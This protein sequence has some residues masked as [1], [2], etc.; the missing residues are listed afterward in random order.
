MTDSPEISVVV[1][2]LDEEDALEL[3]HERLTLA[4]EG[5]GKSYEVIYIDDGS[6]DSSPDILKKLYEAD[7]HVVVIKFR[8][9]FGK[10]AA[11]SCGFSEARGEI[12]F[13][14][15][16]DLQDDPDEIPNFLVKLDEGYDLVSGYKAKRYD[17]WIK[18]ASSRFFNWVVRLTSGVK[19]HDFNCGFKAY[20]SEVVREVDIYG[21][22]H[23]YVPFLAAAR[24]FRVG[25]I[26][27]KHHPRK[28]GRSKYGWDRYM[29]G[30][31]DLLTATVITRF[32][33]KPLHLFGGFGIAC[34]MGGFVI[35]AY[36]TVVWFITHAIGHRPL[37]DLG[38]LLMILGIQLISIGLI[39]EM[40]IF[41]R[42]RGEREY[43]TA[44]VLNH[45]KD[46]ETS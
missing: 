15:D 25:E 22:L 36:L 1:P 40:I 11:L 43:P 2:L 13:T 41:N 37:L 39:G 23:R 7:S 42:P 16:A 21:D 28:Y 19:L 26:K 24:G 17:P 44:Y 38:M 32:S 4:L 31:L 46:K 10:A 20:R 6:T 35:L 8:R 34:L 9:N 14:I 18:V 12:I 45:N 27:V 33:R 3:L 30:F 5:T 29:K